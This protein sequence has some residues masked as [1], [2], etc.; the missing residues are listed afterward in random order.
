MASLPAFGT[1]LEEA[2]GGVEDGEALALDAGI[3]LDD[4]DC[5]TVDEIDVLS[6]DEVAGLD[7]DD[8]GGTVETEEE[9]VVAAWD[10]DIMKSSRNCCRYRRASTP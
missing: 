10:D 3:E 6:D 7:D 8:D 2:G 4:R 5:D 1:P 9:S